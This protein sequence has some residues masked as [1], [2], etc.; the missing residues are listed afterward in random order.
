[1]MTIQSNSVEDTDTSVLGKRAIVSAD[2]S[3]ATHKRTIPLIRQ[4]L[5]EYREIPFIAATSR[6]FEIDKVVLLVVCKYER[7]LIGETSAVNQRNN[8][9]MTKDMIMEKYL[10]LRHSLAIKPKVPEAKSFELPIPPEH[11]LDSCLNRLVQ[12]GL[13]I[14]T[15]HQGG[16]RAITY[17]SHKDFNYS[18]LVAALVNHPLQHLLIKSWHKR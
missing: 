7:W 6:S 8:T 14:S 9:G 5:E 17:C 1:M 2:S 18:D 13:L 12:R 11:L 10:D 15:K 3:D 4:A 16:P